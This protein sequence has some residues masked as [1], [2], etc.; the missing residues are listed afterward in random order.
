MTVVLS[1]VTRLVVA[2]DLVPFGCSNLVSGLLVLLGL[3]LVN[4]SNGRN[5]NLCPQPGVVFRPLERVFI[6]AVLRL[7]IIGLLVIG[8][9]RDYIRSWVLVCIVW[10]VVSILLM[11][12]VNIL[13]SC[14]IAGL[15]VIVL[16]IRGR[17]CIIVILDR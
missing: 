16:N 2:D 1:I 3:R 17:V 15:E 13:S 14:D 12:V 11:L 7:M 6:K 8:P 5:L 9:V 4:V 10:T